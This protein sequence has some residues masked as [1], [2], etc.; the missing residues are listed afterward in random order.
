MPQ[1]NRAGGDVAAE[2]LYRCGSQQGRAATQLPLATSEAE[3]EAATLAFVVAQLADYRVLRRSKQKNPA[4]N[5]KKYFD[6][7]DIRVIEDAADSD[8]E[9]LAR[10]LL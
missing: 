5:L 10:R 7:D 3:F 9:D 8:D 4:R 1:R 6:R 2:V